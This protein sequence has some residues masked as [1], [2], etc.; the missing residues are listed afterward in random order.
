VSEDRLG[1][2]VHAPSLWKIPGQTSVGQHDQFR[3]DCLLFEAC[4]IQP[5]LANAPVASGGRQSGARERR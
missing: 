4:A 3:A 1:P 2:E 5:I